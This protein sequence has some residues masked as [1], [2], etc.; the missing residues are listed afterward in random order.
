MC[1]IQSKDVKIR[2]PRK[3]EWCRKQHSVGE[4]MHYRA[5]KWDGDFLTSYTCLTCERYIKE[6][7]DY[8]V[9]E[10]DNSIYPDFVFEQH[11]KDFA[12][13]KLPIEEIKPSSDELPY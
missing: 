7:R 8:A 4:T 1:V 5:Q 3:C 12:A 2:K 6:H 13:G 11:Y 10:Y 9:D